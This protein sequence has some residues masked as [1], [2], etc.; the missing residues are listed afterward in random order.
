MDNTILAFILYIAGV[1][2]IGVI[3]TCLVFIIKSP[4]KYPYFFRSFDVSRKRNPNIEDCIDRYLIEGCFGVI[5]WHEGEIQ[6][7][8]QSCQQKIAKSH[9]KKI[10]QKQFQKCLDDSHAYRFSLI[11]NQTRYRQENYVKSSYVVSMPTMVFVCDYSFLEKRDN[12]LRAINYECTLNEYK[13]KGQRK[14]MTQELRRKVIERDNYT[15]QNCGKYMPDEVGL[16]IDHIVPISKGGKSV[17][18][19]LQ[20]LCSKCNGSKSNKVLKK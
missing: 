3:I 11:R 20:V 18:S 19:N 12:E 16:Q 7:W 2:I 14:L 4:F 5:Q 17:F 15:C 10:R 1:V 6:K 8:K 13:S 9:L